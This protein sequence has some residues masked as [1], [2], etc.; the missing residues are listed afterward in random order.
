MGVGVGGCGWVGWVG[1]GGW[2]WV[3]VGGHWAGGVRCQCFMVVFYF[4]VSVMVLDI[5]LTPPP[6]FELVA[7][8]ISTCVLGNYPQVSLWLQWPMLGRPCLFTHSEYV[9]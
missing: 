3:G 8:F 6:L 4:Y 9:I 2:V 7:M 5:L 1:V